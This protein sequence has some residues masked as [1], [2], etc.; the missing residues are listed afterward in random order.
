MVFRLHW[1]NLCETS[2]IALPE[3]L[4]SSY[5]T[6]GSKLIAGWNLHTET[7]E[8]CETSKVWMSVSLFDYRDSI[9]EAHD[10]VISAN[11]SLGQNKRTA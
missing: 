5:F 10:D 7:F 2:K 11:D 8:V 3:Y 9:A 6:G 1:Q 4:T